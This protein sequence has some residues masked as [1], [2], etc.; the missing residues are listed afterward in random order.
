MKKKVLSLLAIVSL[1]LT[2]AL[3]TDV[4]AKTKLSKKSITITKGK[5]Y[6]LKVKGTKKKAK[7]T[8]SKKSVAIVSKKGKVTGKKRGSATITA[9][10]GKKKYICKVKVETPSLSTTKKSMAVGSNYTLKLNGCSRAKKFYTSNKSVAAVSSKGVI[11]AKKKGSAKITVKIS[12]KSYYCTVSVYAPAPK[13][14]TRTNPISGYSTYTHDI[15]SYGTKLGNFTIKLL[16]Y[17]S[18]ADAENLV[19][20]ND[21]NDPSTSSTE[22]IYVKYYIIYN[23]G[24]QQVSAIDV[25]DHYY[26]FFNKN[27]TIQLDNKDWGVGFDTVDDMVDVNLYPGGNATCSKAIL[28][29]KGNTPITYR[30]QTGYDSK[31][32]EPIYTWFKTK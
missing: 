31:N 32:F 22:Y 29:S 24:S 1:V 13:T 12:D 11:T 30:L 25:I 2:L 26:G 23:S 5:T 19:L 4:S 7:W 28:I 20:K 8:S 3:P 18:G 17:K 27:A 14:G 16:D 6:T 21:F 10:I 9:K 15:Y